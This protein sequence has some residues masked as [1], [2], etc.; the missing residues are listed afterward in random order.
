[1]AI[2]IGKKVVCGVHPLKPIIGAP[3]G[4]Q[5]L[6]MRNIGVAKLFVR[7]P[8]GI[9]SFELE[10]KGDHWLCGQQLAQGLNQRY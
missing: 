8:S 5:R 6:K 2:Q 10:D 1:M 3:E 7:T 4:K 9:R